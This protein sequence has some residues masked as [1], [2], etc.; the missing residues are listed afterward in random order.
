VAYVGVA[1][2]SKPNVGVMAN[3]GTLSAPKGSLATIHNFRF[4]CVA[5]SL[6]PAAEVPIPCV[7]TVTSVK[8]GDED[9]EFDPVK[10]QPYTYLP[11]PD[12]K[13][14]DPL[15]PLSLNAPMTTAAVQFPPAIAYQ[16][17]VRSA[18]EPP[19]TILDFVPEDLREAVRKLF[20]D[21]GDYA[22]GVRIDDLSYTITTPSP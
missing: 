17:S 13:P 5:R 16:L 20:R 19:G 15:K 22:I 11:K 12:L 1:P 8:R 6:Y 3:N 9:G 7:L 10:S 21:V 4:G 14:K 18:I 2:A